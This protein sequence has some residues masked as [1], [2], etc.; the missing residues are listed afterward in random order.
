MLWRLELT[1]AVS[2]IVAFILSSLHLRS[3]RHTISFGM[4]NRAALV[5]SPKG[6]VVVRDTEV[7][8]PEPGEVQIRVHACTVQPIDAKI[9]R[10]GMMPMEYPTILG[11]Q[12]AGVVTAVGARVTNVAVGDRVVGTTKVVAHKKAKFGGLQRFSILDASGLVE[13][14]E[15]SKYRWSILTKYNRLAMST[16]SNLPH[17]HPPPHLQFFSQTRH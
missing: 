5:E 1:V 16:S 13:V 9:G 17:W 6:E 3:S 12:V 10:L 8:E 11:S 7:F 2:I 15:L 14:S 4:S